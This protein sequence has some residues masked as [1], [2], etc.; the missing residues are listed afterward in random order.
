MKISV[1]LLPVL[2]VSLFASAGEQ[3]AAQSLRERQ[4]DVYIFGEGPGDAPVRVSRDAALRSIYNAQAAQAYQKALATGLPEKERAE[5]EA[6]LKRSQEAERRALADA[7]AVT[8][9]V[10]ELIKS[11][12]DSCQNRDSCSEP[13]CYRKPTGGCSDLCM[14]TSRVVYTGAGRSLDAPTQEL[15]RVS[16]ELSRADLPAAEQAGLLIKS[17]RLYETL[18]SSV[19]APPAKEEEAAPPKMGPSPD[20]SETLHRAEKDLESQERKTHAEIER[21]AAEA[22][23]KVKP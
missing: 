1:L 3:E 15:S 9:P 11:A 8:V 4:G 12:S 19:V 2:A 21:R 16:R 20:E 14:G 5:T 10:E 18:A 7:Q 13:C 22:K 6:A 23:K 17:G